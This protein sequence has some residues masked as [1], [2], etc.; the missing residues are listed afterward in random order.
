MRIRTAVW[1]CGLLIAAG[2]LSGWAA[3]PYRVKVCKEN[4]SYFVYKGKPI[5]LQGYARLPGGDAVSNIKYNYPRD[6]ENAADY[7][8]NLITISLFEPGKEFEPWEKVDDKYD[9]DKLY[10]R[11]FGRLSDYVATCAYHGLLVNIILWDEHTLRPQ[12]EGEWRQ[13]PMNPLNNSNLSKDALDTQN[14]LPGF[15]RTIPALGGNPEVLKYQEALIHKV[16][17]ETSRYRNVIYTLGSESAPKEWFE[18]WAD[19]LHKEA[20]NE[21]ADTVVILPAG[22]QAR[23]GADGLDP[24]SAMDALPFADKHDYLLREAGTPAKAILCAKLAKPKRSDLWV[25]F[26]SGAAG[27]TFQAMPPVTGEDPWKMWM[28]AFKNLTYDV[29]LER[30]RPAQELIKSGTAYCL[31]DPGREYLIY[32]P[33]GGDVK[34]DMSATKGE[35]YAALY[36]PATGNKVREYTVTA[37]PE[38]LFDMLPGLPTGAGE[39][40]YPV[41]G[42]D[43][44]LRVYG[45]G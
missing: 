4:P 15:Y 21:E 12:P 24:S 8:A 7:G 22:S 38:T 31:A 26:A 37:G 27:A 13:N 39:D 2:G 20:A 34:L 33:F 1:L 30:M 3:D 9:L 36:D 10:T 11:Y 5:F 29:K 43:L 41:D 35:C 17:S 25:A 44:L 14:A 42:A 23:A 16:F 18:Y 6:I 40:G 19:F 32:I 45:S 28:N